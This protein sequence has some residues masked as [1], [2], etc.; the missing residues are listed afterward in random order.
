MQRSSNN[1]IERRTKPIETPANSRANCNE[2]RGHVD[3][4]RQR[5]NFLYRREHLMMAKGSSDERE[6]HECRAREL[7][8]KK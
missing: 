3:Q 7:I 6:I 2:T 8:V 1:S 4:V 5:H